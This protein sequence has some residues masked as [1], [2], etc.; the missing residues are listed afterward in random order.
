MCEQIQA[1]WQKLRLLLRP[2]EVAVIVATCPVSGSVLFAGPV[3]GVAKS[4]HKFP[5]YSVEFHPVPDS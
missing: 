3:R 2:L 4:L 5:Q 1:V